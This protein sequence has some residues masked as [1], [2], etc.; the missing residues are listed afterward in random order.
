MLQNSIEKNLEFVANTMTLLITLTI[1]RISVV[2]LTRRAVTVFMYI[3][4][5][6]IILVK[7]FNITVI[8]AEG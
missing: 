7:S 6:H 5:V 1:S 8:I 3:L 4:L 2:T